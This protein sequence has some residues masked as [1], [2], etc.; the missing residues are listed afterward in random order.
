MEVLEQSSQFAQIYNIS[1]VPQEIWDRHDIS[2]V[3]KGPYK[4]ACYTNQSRDLFLDP[5]EEGISS[6]EKNIR[7]L[8]REMRGI[9]FC[10]YSG[11]I[12]RRPL[13]KIKNIGESEEVRYENIDLSQK[14]WLEPKLDGTMIAP[15]YSDGA[16]IWGT[17]RVDLEFHDIITAAVYDDY[18][19]FVHKCLE[20]GM[21]PI[22]EYI[23][24]DNQIVL[25]YSKFA[26][27]LLAIRH[28]KTG[29]YLTR[30]EMKR[31]LYPHPTIAVNTVLDSE[32]DDALLKD[33][34]NATDI[35]GYILCFND[36]RKYKIK[37]DWYV[38]LHRAKSDIEEDHNI[39]QLY[40]NNQLDDLLPKLPDKDLARVENLIR[41]LSNS[42]NNFRDD[43]LFCH[44]MTKNLSNKEFAEISQPGLTRSAIFYIRSGKNLE[45][46]INKQLL[47]F[48]FKKSRWEEFVREVFKWN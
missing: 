22:F 40:L 5:F 6:T 34:Y 39:V 35:E 48:S 24:P 23:S 21:T 16:I 26:L 20:R 32:L 19:P 31:M 8:L 44:Q 47:Y 33:I 25:E 2:L 38:N 28:N 17:K 27:V 41:N 14:H 30:N 29:I 18:Y 7:N 43:I 15:F 37:S 9:I 3:D 13:H 45:E 1:D 36:G 11:D 4:V 12:L 46:F 42:I 10:S